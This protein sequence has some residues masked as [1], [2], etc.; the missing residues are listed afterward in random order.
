MI[1]ALYVAVAC[2][3]QISPLPATQLIANVI[4]YKNP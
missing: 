1:N 4:I 3:T 2:H